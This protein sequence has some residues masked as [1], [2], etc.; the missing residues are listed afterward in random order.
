MTVPDVDHPVV[1]APDK[2]EERQ[3][4]ELRGPREAKHMHD[5]VLAEVEHAV[6]G[7]RSKNPSRTIFS[8][9]ILC[10]TRGSIRF[11]DALHV[12]PGS[13]GMCDAGLRVKA[14]QT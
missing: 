7:W 10:A 8:W 9:Y 14:W 11:D 13:L 4:A 12:L 6:L 3:G 1:H 2:L 5:E